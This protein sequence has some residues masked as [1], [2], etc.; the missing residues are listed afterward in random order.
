MTPEQVLDKL[1]ETVNV[2]GGL[3]AFPDGT[4]APNA[5]PDWIDMGDV[6]LNACAARGV[7]PQIQEDEE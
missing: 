2:T 6:Y 5:D 1:I 4:H 3:I 7:E